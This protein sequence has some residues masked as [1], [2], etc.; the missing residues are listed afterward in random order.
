MIKT[1]IRINFILLKIP[2]TESLSN[3]KDNYFCVDYIIKQMKTYQ[4]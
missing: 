3:V 4:I 2:E 1:I